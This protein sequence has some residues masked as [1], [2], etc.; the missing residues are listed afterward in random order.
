MLSPISSPVSLSSVRH[1]SMKNYYLPFP[2]FIVS[3]K[4]GKRN[5]GGMAPSGAEKRQKYNLSL[6]ATTAKTSMKKKKNNQQWRQHQ[7]QFKLIGMVVVWD[8]I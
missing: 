6:S 8:V 3:A 7:D 4:N 2:F 5:D 1:G